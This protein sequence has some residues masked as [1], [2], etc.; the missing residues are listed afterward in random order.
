MNLNDKYFSKGLLFILLGV[1]FILWSMNIIYIG[2]FG[3][4]SVV[5]SASLIYI[6]N[7]YP[8]FEKFKIIGYLIIVLMIPYYFRVQLKNV[9]A[10][11]FILIGLYMIFIRSNTF[12]KKKGVFKDSRDCV[13]INEKFSQ[14]IVD[15]VAKDLL[16]VKVVGI[17]SDMILNFD[18]CQ[19]TNSDSVDFD[20]IAFMSNI[21]ININPS[22]SIVVNGK[23][24]R[25]MDMPN[26]KVVNIKI[27][28]ILS[29]IDIG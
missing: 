18:N 19:I 6:G 10:I 12:T 17:A 8:E 15:N 9:L 16:N 21:K 2:F 5:A 20:I 13:Y 3:I 1:V 14:L 7:K 26:D 24:L 23:Y 22:W 25:K 28:N 4:I 27:K 11:T 29:T